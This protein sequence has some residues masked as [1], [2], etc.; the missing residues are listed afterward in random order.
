MSAYMIVNIEVTD[1]DRYAE[2]IKVAPAS[3]ARYGGTYIARGGRT[4]KLEGDYEPKRVVILE[5]E[6]FDRGR[7]WWASD[8][9][10][11]PKGLRQ[12]AAITDMIL[13]EGV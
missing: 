1:P 12:S 13:V 5:F 3:V 10:A 7:E 9:Y 6:T 8:E 11:G 4:E 2:Y